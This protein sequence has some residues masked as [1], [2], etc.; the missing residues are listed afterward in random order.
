VC[1]GT[2]DWSK[3]EY[4]KEHRRSERTTRHVFGSRALPCSPL[5][6]SAIHPQNL[7]L[8]S[9]TRTLF[10]PATPS[11][12]ALG[13]VMRPVCSDSHRPAPKGP[14]CSSRPF[15]GHMDSSSSIEK[16]FV[17]PFI[18]YAG[19]YLIVNS[20]LLLC[21]TQELLASSLPS[22]HLAGPNT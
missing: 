19:C 4:S 2:N 8:V 18:L 22:Q 7:R 14:T 5:F 6:R 10:F 17:P 9:R 15:L 20:F 1:L 11:I 21:T 16:H 13:S 12:F 3:V